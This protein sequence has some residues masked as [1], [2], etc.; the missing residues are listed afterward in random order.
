MRLLPTLA[1]LLLAGGGAARAQAGCPPPVLKVVLD[2]QEVPATG[3]AF[4]PKVTLAVGP[5]PACA[6]G[7]NYRF[8]EAEVT[9]LRGRRPVLSTLLVH[10]PEIDLKYLTGIAQPGDRIHVFVSYKNLFVVAADG[11]LRPY[12]RPELSPGQQTGVGN[13]LLTD[14]ARG[15]S[16]NWRLVQK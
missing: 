9:L 13:A 10:R 2:S 7:G 15:I 11:R 14:E 4:A 12:L 1:L 16:F 5:D 8:R 6:E 3:A